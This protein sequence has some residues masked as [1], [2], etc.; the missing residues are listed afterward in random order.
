MSNEYYEK[1]LKYKKKYLELKKQT[2]GIQVHGCIINKYDRDGQLVSLL[3][4]NIRI[5][6][7]GIYPNKFSTS[8]GASYQRSCRLWLWLI[9]ANMNNPIYKD[10]FDPDIS[11]NRN[12]IEIY[13]IN[14]TRI[15]FQVIYTKDGIEHIENIEIDVNPI[16]RDE[17]LNVPD[18]IMKKIVELCGKFFPQ[19]PIPPLD[20]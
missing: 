18:T 13:R 12:H 20:I 7:N 8:I 5:F 16:N 1:Y 19:Y 10:N 17:D 2:G 14:N 9:E 3:W 6:L 4:S 11:G 15:G